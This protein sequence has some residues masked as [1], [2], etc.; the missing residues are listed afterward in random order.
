[1]RVEGGKGQED[2]APSCAVFAWR[3]P[4][5]QVSMLGVSGIH[6]AQDHGRV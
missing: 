6:I 1:M 5:P 2:K 3:H 4:S